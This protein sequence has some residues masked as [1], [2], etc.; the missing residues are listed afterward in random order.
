MDYYTYTSSIFLFK[1][2][3]F[4]ELNKTYGITEHL[5]IRDYSEGSVILS[6]ETETVG[7]GIVINGNVSINSDSRSTSPILRTLTEGNIFGAASLFNSGGYTT[8]VIAATDC[9][10][11]YIS[12]DVIMTLCKKNSTIA[13]NY[14][15]FLSDRVSF[16][17]KK[18]SIFTK[19]STEAKLAYYLAEQCDSNSSI[20]ELSVSY[21]R[22]AD[23]LGIGRASLYRSLDKMC[24]SKIIERTSKSITVLNIEQLKSLIK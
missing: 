3:N 10:I 12:T 2:C 11:A 16:L 19:G 7:I 1:N 22:L 6:D 8:T 13:I 17:N 15:K 20:T 24:D 18:V 14:I 23:M 4:F 5:I 9:K 21:S